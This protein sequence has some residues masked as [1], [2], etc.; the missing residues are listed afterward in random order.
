MQGDIASAEKL[1]TLGKDLMG[2]SKTYSVSGSEY[3]KDLAYIQGVATAVADI[4]ES[5]LGTS[6]SSDLKPSTTTGTTTP[7]IETTNSTMTTEMQAMREEFNA[8]LFAIAKF[9][10]NV[11]SRTERWDDGNRVMVGIQ[12]ENGDTPVPVVVTP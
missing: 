7:T 2:L 3:A 11:D 6:I 4:Q 8:G 12:P 5:G 9:V 10:Q 1:L